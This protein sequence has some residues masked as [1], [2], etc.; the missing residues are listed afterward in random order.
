VSEFDAV[1]RLQQ[2]D[3]N[4]LD[5]LYALYAHAAVRLAYSITG[6][7]SYVY[8]DGRLSRWRAPALAKWLATDWQ[9]DTVDTPEETIQAY[10]EA[11][12]SG[13]LSSIPPLLSTQRRQNMPDDYD[14]IQTARLISIDATRETI[15]A[16][17][18]L[19]NHPDLCEVR[20]YWVEFVLTFH[21]V[22]SMR[23][24]QHSWNY[25]LVKETEDGPWLIADWGY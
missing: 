4:A 18:Y 13:R 8:R 1:L 2:G 14:N 17:E 3:H 15:H 19:K 23:S 24:G 10:F 9:E 22:I 12:D 25:V 16:T 5:D 20:I 6:S 11:L 7:E 21:E